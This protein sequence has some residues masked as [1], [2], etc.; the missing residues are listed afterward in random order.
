MAS[1]CRNWIAVAC[2]EHAR[3]G[4]AAGLQGF[5]QVGHGKHAP[6]KRISPGDRVAYYA[7]SLAIGSRDRLQNFISIGIVQPKEPYQIDM[8]GGFMPYRRDVAYVRSSE[9]P[10][11]ALLDEF[12]FVHNRARWGY[13]FRFGLFEIGEADMMRIARAM[14]VEG[15]ALHLLTL[16]FEG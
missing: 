14:R 8:G 2:A 3:R 12:D 1:T 4:C 11:A 15:D 5:M 7:P 6:L 13:A 16:D 9:A 10:I